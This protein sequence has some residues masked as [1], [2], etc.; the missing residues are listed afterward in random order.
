MKK[1][2]LLELALAASNSLTNTPSPIP[3]TI[4][5]KMT[6]EWGT[7]NQKYLN[8]ANSPMGNIVKEDE[9]GVYVIFDA[10]DVLAYCTAKGVVNI[11]IRRKY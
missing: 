7:T 6:G 5:I 11:D 10:I 1:I 4:A 3:P 9:D 8:G 2:N